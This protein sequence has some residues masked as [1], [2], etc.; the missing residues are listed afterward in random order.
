MGVERRNAERTR[1]TGGG[2][3]TET[4]FWYEMEWA[5]CEIESRFFHDKS[6][7]NEC[8]RDD[9]PLGTQMSTCEVV[10][11]GDSF[12]LP[13]SLV[14]QLSSFQNAEDIAG[15]CVDGFVLNNSRYYYP[16]VRTQPQIGDLRVTFEYIELPRNCC[17]ASGAERGWAVHLLALSPNHK[18]Q[19]N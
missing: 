9:I 6:K 13:S 5:T 8:S 18:G 2:E 1:D 3:T 16:A 4:V 19:R 17:C 11:L 15:E 14:D 10:R 12:L 7:R